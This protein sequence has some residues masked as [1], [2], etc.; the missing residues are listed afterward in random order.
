M[1]VQQILK[2][3]DLSVADDKIT[4]EVNE[5][6]KLVTVT[7]RFPTA[8]QTNT[9]VALIGNDNDNDNDN[10]FWSELQGSMAEFSIAQVGEVQQ[11]EVRFDPPHAPP[12]SPPPPPPPSPSP[13]PPSPPSPP[14]PPAPTGSAPPAPPLNPVPEIAGV[15]ASSSELEVSEIAGIAVGS[16]VVTLLLC[17]VAYL[18]RNKRRLVKANADMLREINSE[19]VTLERGER[20]S[21]VGAR[22]NVSDSAPGSLWSTRTNSAEGLAEGSA[23]EVSSERATL[24]RVAR[25][26]T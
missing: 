25:L 16:V 1:A 23:S 19:D 18:V 17:L 10:V 6:E 14:S 5:A 20:E 8:A 2:A 3:N 22:T 9:A 24:A 12:S 13:P 15:T 26:R 21:E 7:T 4:V 11:I